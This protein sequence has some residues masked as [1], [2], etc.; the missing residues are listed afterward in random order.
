VSSK[1]GCE[2]IGVQS[3]LTHVKQGLFYAAIALAVASGCG[4]Q[5]SNSSDR[6]APK[7]TQTPTPAPAGMQQYW[8]RGVGVDAPSSWKPNAVQCGTPMADTVIVD[9]TGEVTP[10]CL[11]TRPP[12]NIS[13]IE[14]SSG[15]NNNELAQYEWRP[16]AIHGIPVEEANKRTDDGRHERL[17][18]FPDREVFVDITSS[19][20]AL[21]DATE[22]SLQVV[23]RDPETGCVVHTNAYDDG[24]P[25]AQGDAAELLP[26]H[27]ASATGCVYVRGW[28]E[29]GT[30]VT[31]DKLATLIDAVQAAPAPTDERAPDDTNC[32]SV[33]NLVTP[34]DDPPMVL[35]FDYA[36]S[37]TWTVVA[38]IS[39]C[40]RWQSTISSGSVTRRI[41]QRLLLALPSLWNM[42]PDPDSMDP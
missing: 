38:K 3:S 16:T 14:L 22:Q 32:E 12:T 30:R 7:S 33:A 10:G 1:D 19:D 37:S 29:Q 20:Q 11:I 9:Y 40:T 8:L 4:S 39:P 21:I 31:G 23:D 35:H 17:V 15:T 41:D 24:K 25:P 26:G 13:V 28:L 2:P 27:P 36:D 34:D 42:Y 6:L 5:I 18:E